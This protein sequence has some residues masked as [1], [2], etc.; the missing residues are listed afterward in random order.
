MFS[1]VIAEEIADSFVTINCLQPGHCINSLLFSLQ[2]LWRE[3]GELWAC[4][5]GMLTGKPSCSWSTGQDSAEGASFLP[6]VKFGEALPI[7]TESVEGELLRDLKSRCWGKGACPVLY[8][9]L[10]GFGGCGGIFQLTAPIMEN[11]LLANCLWCSYY[12]SISLLCPVFSCFLLALTLPWGLSRRD[13]LFW[14]F[15]LGSS[16][17]GQETFR[18]D[19]LG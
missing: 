7:I 5:H 16:L 3:R 15:R 18:P 14:A 1:L 11:S 19:V 4:G 9:N 12:G 2:V 6:G 8:R 17:L 10:D 13:A